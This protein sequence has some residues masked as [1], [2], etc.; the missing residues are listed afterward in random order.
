MAK[1]KG[2]KRRLTLKRSIRKTLAAILM[3]TALIVGAIPTQYLQAGSVQLRC[4][5]C[6][7]ASEEG[8]FGRATH[9]ICDTCGGSYSQ[10]NP[11][12][13]PVTGEEYITCD[14]I[15]TTVSAQ[16]IGQ[17]LKH[18]K[19]GEHYE[20]MRE[21]IHYVCPNCG[22]TEITEENRG[23]Y[24]V[25]EEEIQA[26]CE[27][28]NRE[29]LNGKIVCKDCGEEV[30]DPDATF[31]CMYCTAENRLGD[32]ANYGDG[33]LHCMQCGKAQVLEE[34]EEES[35]E[36]DSSS[37]RTK[38]RRAVAPRASVSSNDWTYDPTKL[39]KEGY[40]VENGIIMKVATLGEYRNAQIPDPA[41][42][43]SFLDRPS[44]IEINAT[45]TYVDGTM[46]APIK[47]VADGAFKSASQDTTDTSITGLI[48]NTDMDYI[49]KEAFRNQ[50]LLR[51]VTIKTGT[52]GAIENFAFADCRLL[53]NFHVDVDGSITL[54]QKNTFFG[55]NLKELRISGS[56]KEVES[57]VMGESLD[58]DNKIT[59][60]ILRV[61]H[62]GVDGATENG[63]LEVIQD[64]A[65]RGCKELSTLVLN[66]TKKIGISAFENCQ[67]IKEVVFPVSLENIEDSAFKYCSALESV[68]IP[69]AVNKLGEDAFFNNAQLK[70]VT[71]EQNSNL[72]SIGASAFRGC[73]RLTD[74]TFGGDMQPSTE[75]TIGD[76]AFAE[77]GS[78]ERI[79]Q[80]ASS[81]SQMNIHPNF[82][83][84]VDADPN[85]FYLL[86]Q[87]VKSLGAANGI[88]VFSNCI[89]L[90]RIGFMDNQTS[91]WE[92]EIPKETFSG[93][94]IYN[95]IILDRDTVIPD[96]LFLKNGDEKEQ[97]VLDN[98]Y[99]TGYKFWSAGSATGRKTTAYEYV[100][101]S[102][103]YNTVDGT[104]FPIQCLDKGPSDPW[105][106]WY[107]CSIP[108]GM[109]SVDNDTGMVNG[110]VSSGT[111]TNPV[112]VVIP[113]R[114]G[115]VA[116]KGIARENEDRK[117]E[118]IF[119]YV[120]TIR[121]IT[122]PDTEGFVIKDK[123]L[124]NCGRLE[125]VIFVDPSKVIEIGENAFFN[126]GHLNANG[127]VPKL[128][129]VDTG[130][131]MLEGP[132]IL[133]SLPFSGAMDGSFNVFNDNGVP[134]PIIYKTP[135]PAELYIQ[136]I[137]DKNTLIDYKPKA[138]YNDPANPDINRPS[139]SD[140]SEIAAY[141]SAA[142]NLTIPEGVETIFT[143]PYGELATVSG[144]STGYANTVVGILAGNNT[145][146]NVVSEGLIELPDLAFFNSTAIQKVSFS[147]KLKRSGFGI[148]P[149][150]LCTG[151]QNNIEF[152]SG[153]LLCENLVIYGV[154]NGNKT[155]VLEMLPA[156]NGVYPPNDTPDLST[157]TSIAK[158]AF[159]LCPD[160]R[161]ADFSTAT[162]LETIPEEAFAYSGLKTGILPESVDR[163]DEGA[164]AYSTIQT[165]HIPNRSV[166]IR[167]T[168]FIGTEGTEL[169][170]YAKS[171]VETYYK[172]YKDVR[173]Y[174]LTFVPIEEL[175]YYKVEFLDYDGKVLSTQ[176]IL[177][178]LDAKEPEI[179]E[180]HRPGWKFTGWS[181]SFEGINKDTTLVAQYVQDTGSSGSSSSSGAGSGSSGP[182]SSSG[183]SGSTSGG[184]NTSSGRTSSSKTSSS[185]S[186]KSSSSKSSSGSNGSLSGLTTPIL[187]AIA[188]NA[189]GV[190][191]VTSGNTNAGVDIR[192]PG[193]SNP[194]VSSANVNGSDGN[195]IV[196]IIYTDEAR[197][198]SQESLSK[199]Y[200]QLDSIAYFP[201][202]IS[203]YDS[204]G[205]NKITD[206]NGMTVDI[207]LPLP[208]QL[209]QFGGNVRPASIG[210]NNTLEDLNPRFA[211]INQ[212]PCVSFTA[213]HFSP[214]VLY[215][216]TNN[217]VA[218]NVFD[219]TPTTGDG[220]H[221]KWFLAV[222]LAALS[223]VLF[224]KKDPQPKKKVKTA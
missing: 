134:I 203:L 60:E 193:I 170:G 102:V 40:Y 216:D 117:D 27:H 70:T 190:T 165:A 52:I 14:C 56:I 213:T 57:Y 158:Q 142:I 55:T 80:L 188:P 22:G 149:F 114:V 2:K 4:P 171:A 112:D 21:E 93:C 90:R 35:Q 25:S 41:N 113:S 15:D 120:D 187:P 186:S 115:D 209:V 104:G 147:D 198:A 143:K 48:I 61:D 192:Q 66:G 96:D 62:Q 222:G 19:K 84:I 5:D 138:L 161:T 82:K 164:F 28:L 36:Q 109:I 37:S 32:C 176:T 97:N 127:R 9:Y 135:F 179:A 119:Q 87:N 129:E 86:P 181:G 116:V 145:L 146:R 1:K 211:M 20:G 13:D 144:N 177:E 11:Q 98:F 51:N 155:S 6:H 210:A 191:P 207:T 18:V 214:Y 65:F 79:G 159:K 157:I 196:R 136:N 74:F 100:M 200:G 7:T 132:L 153:D 78:L 151:I 34:E 173:G 73:T 59:L 81:A 215:V 154:D 12:I 71:I 75:L 195:Y 121:T 24:E 77:C 156:Y 124:S 43:G 221:P 46:T 103:D 217:L 54:L 199:V 50:S 133:D 38:A 39:C 150:Q 208:D 16:D 140:Q 160:V 108:G 131:C 111:E 137:S 47:E 204:T 163:I 185:K 122:I 106:P 29:L 58:D 184:G 31:L 189:P 17:P 183:G 152:A 91:G 45:A 169:Q 10:I 3:I 94:K 224:A 168:A 180:N 125:K 49:G 148:A 174:D 178:G 95:F 8:A 201:M 206:L 126:S 172:K 85:N 202:D 101:K 83:K 72:V 166:S 63:S 218:N 99:V 205:T 26:N 107:E 194:D 33:L 105:D 219:T 44:I 67:K 42:P 68:R 212:V 162:L 110:F 89:S 175:K 182:G 88:G 30:T 167:D 139:L 130:Y 223:V 23:D 69:A 220:I 53:S 197:N 64:N 123:A 76:G 128:G 141:D 92:L 118:P